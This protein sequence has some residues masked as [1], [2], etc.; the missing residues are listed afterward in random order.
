M[1]TLAFSFG[2]VPVQGTVSIGL[3]GSDLWAATAKLTS[4][5]LLNAADKALYQSKTAGRNRVN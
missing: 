5:G 3:A 1:Q 4:M 2:Q